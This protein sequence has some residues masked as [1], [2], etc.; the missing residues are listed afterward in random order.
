MG[1]N[2]KLQF[3][4]RAALAAAA[5]A[6]GAPIAMAQTV[7]ANAAT[8]PTLQEVVVTGSR[9]AVAP[10][11]ISISPITTVTAA[12][13]AQTGLI[14]T[15]DILNS[16]PQVTAEQSGG[17]SI[18]SVGVATVSLRGLGSQRT[19]VLV[20]GRRMNPGGAGGI[21]G[22]NSNAPDIN[23]LPADLIER[24]DV[25]TGGASA[26]YG[27]DAVAGVVNFILNTH[28]EGVKVDANYAFNNH[29]NDN[30]Q[31]LT[32]LS[33]FGAATPQS[34]VNTGQ[35]KDVS[36]LAGSNFADGKGNATAYFTYLNSAPA[37]G[38]QF[39]HAGCTLI[40]GK[41]GNS[42]IKCGGSGTS[43]H[44]QFLML[45]QSGVGTKAFATTIVDNAVDP[46]T[47]AFRPFNGSDLYNYGALSYFQRAAERYTAGSFL[48]YDVNDHAS[49]YTETMFARNTSH[50][51]Y[52]P[53]GDFFG[54]HTI[55]CA[56]PLLTASERTTLCNPTTFASNRAQ[57]P[58]NTGDQISLY[59]A[60]RNVEGGG[61]IDNYTSDSIRQVI[62]VKGKISD[63]WTYDA[64]AQVGIT[65]FQDIESNFLGTPQIANALNVVADPKTGAPVCA[66]VLNGSDPACVPWNVWVPGGVTKAALNYLSVP[67]TYASN[68]TEYIADASVTGELGKYGVKLPTATDGLTVNIG[69]EYRE[70]KFKFDPDYIYLNGLTGG[71]APSKAIDGGL[72]VWE[73]FTEARLPIMNDIPGAYNLSAD[74]G[75]RYSNYTLGFKT[76]TYKFGVEWAPVQDVRFRAGYNKAI[77]APNINEL[78]TPA[79]VGAGG[80][81][82][83]CWGSAPSLSQAQ[84]VN[85]GVSPAQ[86]GHINVN[87]AAQINTQV[88]GNVGLQPE[89]ADTYTF[90]IVLQPT[91]IPNLVASLDVY[92]I[93]I[94][95]TITSLSSNTIINDC[96]L[97]GD[98]AL[99]A[100][101]HRGPTGSLWLSTAN[102]V[103]ATNLNIG[104]VSTK[105]IDLALHYR[106]D[107]GAAGK[108]GFNLSSSYTKD[109]LT[110]PLPTGGTYDC[111]GYWGTTC[112]APTPHYRQVFT[113][114]WATPWA[115]L[116]FSVKWRLIGPSSVDRSS[117]DPQLSA[118]FYVSTK[119]IPGYNYIDLSAAMAVTPAVNVRLGVNN[120]TDK[121]PPLILNGTLSDCPNSTCNDNSW[122]GT[123]DVLGRYLYA[124]VSVKF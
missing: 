118:P 55:S 46:K 15:E 89:K 3:A 71:G 45:G 1:N 63:A 7:A 94:K 24:V 32:Y 23:Q 57:Y 40:G 21:S 58:G 54:L 62:G 28:Y 61:R 25:L 16:L 90:G 27:A 67:A 120:L 22:G 103:T 29:K 122:A 108:L 39:D 50:A 74:A 12:D 80:T 68:S 33:N 85:T 18:S 11:D 110:Q 79:V 106:A 70:E 44:G 14:R 91:F 47:G 81:A 92:S 64:Y 30:Q 77:R 100:L 101:I 20:D 83:P 121:N 51:Q 95:Q 76:N 9:I 26:V 36:I 31:Y 53:S 99:C 98:A 78:F 43:A 87:P 93:K 65:Q 119:H 111:A 59:V 42:P 13:I 104:T 17:L 114:N 37:I 41:T 123:Y 97:T 113:T 52:G 56:D 48:H 88:G 117:G 73:A 5:A 69:A 49:L 10:N 109:S 105:G 60:R 124:H 115:G 38:Y 8:E 112:G 84:C 82:D 102:F 35:T 2:R 6:S 86:Y 116:D 66:S 72:H 19:L 75:Y 107:I 34:T 4:I 96:A